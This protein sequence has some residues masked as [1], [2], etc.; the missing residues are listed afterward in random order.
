M[1]ITLTLMV[2]GIVTPL[3][4]HAERLQDLCELI[5]DQYQAQE[6]HP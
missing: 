1:S 4:I 5:E 6:D 2:G 3:D